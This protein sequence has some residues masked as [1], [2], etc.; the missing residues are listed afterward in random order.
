MHFPFQ[1]R[2]AAF[3]RAIQSLR[4]G[5][6]GESGYGRRV[7]LLLTIPTYED[8]AALDVRR[9]ATTGE[10]YVVRTVWR[11][12]L[13]TPAVRE[14]RETFVNARILAV[15]LDIATTRRPTLVS[16]RVPVAADHL[17]AL[18]DGVAAATV[19]CHVRQPKAP[20]TATIYE[21]TFGD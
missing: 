8:P 18:L 1:P 6:V 5:R 11:R 21:L 20:I 16:S 17:E 7:A 10:L 15:D 14:T 2:N 19:A 9:S 4:D 13:D 3:D 12:A